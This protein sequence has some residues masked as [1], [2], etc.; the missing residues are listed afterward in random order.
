M[1]SIMTYVFL[2]GIPLIGL[3]GILKVGEGLTAPRP[4]AGDWI[5]VER[6]SLPLWNPGCRT[7]AAADE[8]EQGPSRVHIDQSGARADVSWSGVRADAFRVTLRG[9]SLEGK[10]A[11][12]F[13]RRCPV[14]VLTF[15]AVVTHLNER[16]R[17]LGELRAEKCD[18]CPIIPVDWRRRR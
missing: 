9:D 13:D 12:T 16:E 8:A 4:V 6:E 18:T 1:R 2:V 3:V 10:L 14:D 5:A 17:I 15:R 11:L 7:A